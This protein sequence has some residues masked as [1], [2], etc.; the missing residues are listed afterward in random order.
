MLE[1]IIGPMFSGKTTYLL[2]KAEASSYVGKVLYINHII[3]TRNPNGVISTHNTVISLGTKKFDAIKATSL[4]E[5]TDEMLAPYS[6]VCIDE[7]HFFQKVYDRVRHIIDVLKKDVY[8][9]GL[10][11][12]S[13][14]IPFTNTDFLNVVS[15]ATDIHLL[16]SA[17]CERCAR[18]NKKS[19]AVYTYRHSSQTTS[20]I[21]VGG[22]EKFSPVCGECWL[23]CSPPLP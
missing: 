2:H 23:E 14:K 13:Q 4:E 17:Y 22:S 21:L 20:D 3:D 9:A 19:V 11:G 8:I 6:F 1:L 12:T 15:I 16:K 5:V 7:G 18:V 10:S